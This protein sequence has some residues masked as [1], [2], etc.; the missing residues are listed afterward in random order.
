MNPTQPSK[1][2]C[3][4]L[5]IGW[6]PWANSLSDHH[7]TTKVA[8]VS[9]LEMA[10]LSPRMF[11]WESSSAIG[12]GLYGHAQEKRHNQLRHTQKRVLTRVVEY[13]WLCSEERA[14]LDSLLL[15][16]LTPKYFLAYHYSRLSPFRR[17]VVFSFFQNFQENYG[18][19]LLLGSKRY[20][21][22]FRIWLIAICDSN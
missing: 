17:A 4:V 1:P 18:Y 16:S 2:L 21:F 9:S 15:P 14:N 19:A 7:D 10:S 22:M 11:Y 20:V 5:Y 12:D 6:K 13:R 8:G 3:I